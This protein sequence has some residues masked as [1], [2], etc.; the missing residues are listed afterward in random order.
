MNAFRDRLLQILQDPRV[1]KLMQDPR[2]QRLVIRGFRMRGRLEGAV[3]R[4]VQRIA[5][6][7]DLATQR[8]VRALQKRIR[9]LEKALRETEERLTETE[10]ARAARG[11]S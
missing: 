5:G 7:L 11:H 10:D 8:D 9:Y 1:V 3:D 4:R 6:R 2:M